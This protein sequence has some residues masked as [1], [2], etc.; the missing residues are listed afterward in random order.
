MNR[1][2]YFIT[3]VLGIFLLAAAIFFSCNTSS[4]N[5][6]HEAGSKPNIILITADDLGWADLACYGSDL[7]ETPH[8][9]QLARQGM[10]FT[11]AYAAAS[12]CTPT[13]A[14]LMTG[15]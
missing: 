15:K 7:H 3:A 2:S 13:R 1:N 11:N 12:V 10:K 5:T 6:N 9:D 4:E 14:S 8:L